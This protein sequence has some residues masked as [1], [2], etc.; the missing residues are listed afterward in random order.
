MSSR[1]PFPASLFCLQHLS[2]ERVQSAICLCTAWKFIVSTL[3]GRGGSRYLHSEIRFFIA[4]DYP[5]GMSTSS[6]GIG[7]KDRPRIES[8]VE[9]KARCHE[10]IDTRSSSIS[11]ARRALP[12]LFFS[13]SQLSLPTRVSTSHRDETFPDLEGIEK[14]KRNQG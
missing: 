7:T 10:N 13:F 12:I 1:R 14:S 4:L 3:R 8:R 6:L 5:L 11:D 9:E 2:R